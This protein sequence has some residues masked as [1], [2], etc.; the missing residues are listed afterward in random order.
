M[1]ICAYPTMHLNF[2]LI[3]RYYNSVCNCNLKSKSIPI[4][5]SNTGALWDM[6]NRSIECRKKVYKYAYCHNKMV[7]WRQTQNTEILI[8][9]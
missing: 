6:C 3:Y 8:G 2:R 4:L 7:Q 1:K 9:Y 5:A